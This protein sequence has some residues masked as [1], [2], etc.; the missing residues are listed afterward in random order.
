VDLES[1]IKSY[2]TNLSDD[3][4][5]K[6]T[7]GLRDSSSRYYYPVMNSII[8]LHEYYAV[9]IGDG[10]DDRSEMPFDKKRVFEYYNE[11]DYLLKDDNHIY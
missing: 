5:S 9:Y 8:L 3:L 1:D 10:V 4:I 6:V 11:I 2:E 7:Y